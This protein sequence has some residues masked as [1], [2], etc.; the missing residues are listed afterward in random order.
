MGRPV[1]RALGTGQSNISVPVPSSCIKWSFISYLETRSLMRFGL[2]RYE[3]VQTKG[4]SAEMWFA[5][6]YAYAY[7]PSN[8]W[9]QYRGGPSAQPTSAA[10]ERGM[11][12]DGP[13]PRD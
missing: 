3:M 9:V 7:R 4:R 1:P 8:P 11:P 2:A 13:W 10:P 6:E 5:T 12:D